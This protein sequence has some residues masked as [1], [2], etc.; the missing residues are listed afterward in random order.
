[1]DDGG[2]GGGAS[3]GGGSGGGGRAATRPSLLGAAVFWEGG[4]PL[5]AVGAIAVGDGGGG[6]AHSQ[7]QATCAL[8][9]A[10]RTL[11]GSQVDGGDDER[12]PL[13]AFLELGDRCV[14]IHACGSHNGVCIAVACDNADE[15]AGGADE[16]TRAAAV[17][18]ARHVA[19][20]LDAQ[21]EN[22]TGG[23]GRL[24]K[25]VCAAAA[26][27]R[28][29]VDSYDVHTASASADARADVDARTA[30]NGFGIDECTAPELREFAGAVMCGT[31]SCPP[32]VAGWLAPVL[33]ARGVR[34]AAL[35]DVRTGGVLVREGADASGAARAVFAPHAVARPSL[36]ALAAGAAEGAA[37][38][39]VRAA[40]V[41]GFEGL[42]AAALGAGLDTAFVVCYAKEGAFAAVGEA[43]VGAAPAHITEALLAARAAAA[44]DF[45]MGCVAT[46]LD[47]G[48]GDD[49]EVEEVL[50]HSPLQAERSAPVDM[51][52]TLGDDLVIPLKTPSDVRARRLTPA[53]TGAG[54]ARG[55]A[56]TDGLAST[57]RIVW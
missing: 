49:S 47:A 56:L 29:A 11:Y 45:G 33:R 51:G 18:A 4:A 44:E 57:P 37:G 53:A 36:V 24:S 38:A 22:G 27:A 28:A 30:A 32:H 2:G 9:A 8:L 40:R 17:L 7:L 42:H 54:A 46:H 21:H 6:G 20:Q 16:A 3:V 10:L 5:A 19:A 41:A 23:S 43:D 48:D 52:A 50:A 14:A 15:A 31:V 35:L 39:S 13:E 26:R 12:P 1:M 25:L 34:A 55:A